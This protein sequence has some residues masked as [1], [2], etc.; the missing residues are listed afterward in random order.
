[1]CGTDTE[2][3]ALAPVPVHRYLP[4][5]KAD[6][7]LSLPFPTGDNTDRNR[8]YRMSVDLWES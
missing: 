3:D 4:S 8:K 2:A 1:M 6:L 5:G 7:S